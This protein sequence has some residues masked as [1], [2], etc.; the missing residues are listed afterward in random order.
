LFDYP[1]FG[2]RSGFFPARFLQIFRTLAQILRA[3]QMARPPHQTC[4]RKNVFAAVVLS[5]QR[6]SIPGRNMVRPERIVGFCPGTTRCHRRFSQCSRRT[7]EPEMEREQNIRKMCRTRTV[8]IAE[9]RWQD[10][11]VFPASGTSFLSFCLHI[12]L[13]RSSTLQ[14]GRASG[15]FSDYH[16]FSMRREPSPTTCCK[17]EM[18][19]SSPAQV[20]LRCITRTA[21]PVL[22]E[23]VRLPIVVSWRAT[24][25]TFVSVPAR[26]AIVVA[27]R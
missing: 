5:F 9:G 18:A 11:A 14:S 16:S 8:T 19:A 26:S 13:G 7:S 27:G 10:K 22:R 23:N 17:S 4:R 2:C 21:F 20:F 15:A 24:K 1:F 25:T 3:H 12:V 6:A